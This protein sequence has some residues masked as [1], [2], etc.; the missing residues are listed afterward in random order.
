LEKFASANRGKKK[1]RINLNDTEGNTASSSA[2]PKSKPGAYDR[3]FSRRFQEEGRLQ[4]K[5]SSWYR[6]Q[7]LL[8]SLRE[9]R[10]TEKRISDH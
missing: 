9:K 2:P 3:N 7:E 4:G 5:A 10:F 6:K 8:S 1:R